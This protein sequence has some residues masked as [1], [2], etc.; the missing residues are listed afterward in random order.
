V[1]ANN[2]IDESVLSALSLAF[3]QAK[4]D[5]ESVEMYENA[6]N[7]L[8]ENDSMASELFAAYIRVGNFKKTQQVLWNNLHL[9]V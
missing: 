9:T 2:P 4:A 6:F 8:P 3:K 5:E 7:L 1:Q